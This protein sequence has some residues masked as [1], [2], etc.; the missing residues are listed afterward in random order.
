MTTSCSNS[1]SREQTL[2]KGWGGGHPSFGSWAKD[3]ESNQYP[4]YCINFTVQ[5][6][7]DPAKNEYQE[8]DP[9]KVKLANITLAT[10]ATKC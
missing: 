4:Y 10:P 9:G 1:A 3:V 2:K 8:K 7:I 5:L 6:Q